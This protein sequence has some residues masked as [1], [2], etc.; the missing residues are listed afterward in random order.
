MESHKVS[1]LVEHSSDVRS[2]KL[3]LILHYMNSSALLQGGSVRPR[4]KPKALSFKD[5]G[6]I[7]AI[8]RTKEEFG[9]PFMLKAKAMSTMAREAIVRLQGPNRRSPFVPGGR[10]RSHEE[11]SIRY[12]VFAPTQV[13]RGLDETQ[14]ECTRCPRTC[15]QSF[16]S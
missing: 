12:L 11:N 2:R 6:K 14:S 15:R 8:K 16:W 10:N 13:D 7:H 9:H 1:I 5:L 3:P 4:T